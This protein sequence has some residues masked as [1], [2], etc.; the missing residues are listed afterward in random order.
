LHDFSKIP[1]F[2]IHPICVEEKLKVEKEDQIISFS[3][4]HLILSNKKEE[5]E[6]QSVFEKV[7][8]N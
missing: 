4:N 3:E 8:L 1:F 7:I 5:Q 2:Q 6:N